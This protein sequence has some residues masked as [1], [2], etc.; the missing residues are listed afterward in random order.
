LSTATVYEHPA[1][2][3]EI[4]L[5]QYIRTLLRYWRW[6]VGLGLVAAVLAFA[7]STILPPQYEATALV[8]ITGPR[9]RMQFDP[10]MQDVPF[11]PRQFTKGY[12]AI[13]TGDELLTT[14]LEA[15]GSAMLSLEDLKGALDA[16]S[17]GDGNLVQLRAR[18]DDPAEAARLANAWAE[19]Y[20]AHLNALYGQKQE[21]STL[22]AQVA[23]AKAAVERTDQELARLRREYGIGFRPSAAPDV[24]EPLGIVYQLQARTTLLADYEARAG[25]IAQLLG[26]ARAV[27]ERADGAAPAIVSGLI[28]DMLGLGQLNTVG[29]PQVQINLGDLDVRAS[30]AA[31]VAALEAKQAA[32]QEAIAKLQNEVASLQTDVAARQMQLEQLLREQE[33]SQQTYLTLAKKLEENRVE[34]NGDVARI[35]SRAAVP[36]KPSSPRRMFNTALAAVVAVLVAAFGALFAEYWRQGALRPGTA[37]GEASL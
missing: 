8:T 29:M 34:V 1:L 10:R 24:V 25:K 9:Y 11:D 33:V 37:T 22:E 17:V 18:A 20:V 28:A 5:R 4:D 13:A 6:I 21:L 12:A 23:Q 32:T 16:Q 26:E 15:T 31:L 14:L 19:R 27:M 7:I 36:Q 35:A 2:E 3:D 30:L